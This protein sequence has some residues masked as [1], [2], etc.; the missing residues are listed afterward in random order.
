MTFFKH[1][2]NDLV[3]ARYYA[4]LR[5]IPVVIM[6][7]VSAMATQIMVFKD[8]VHWKW[9]IAMP[10]IMMGLG[11]FVFFYWLAHRN[12]TPTIKT[13]RFR[14][15]G[16]SFLLVLAG[17]ITVLGNLHL[18]G[19]T[20]GY[21]RYFIIFQTTLYGFCFAFILNKIGLAAYLYNLLIIPSVI[22][23]LF[24]AHIEYAL[25]LALMISIFEVGMLMTMNASANVFDSLVNAKYETQKLVDE[26]R[27]LANHDFL[28]NLAN[29]RLF[30][31]RVEEQLENA[32][33]YGQSF[34]VGIVDLDNFKPVNDAYGHH[35]GDLVLVEV[36]RRLSLLLPEILSF[37]RLGGDEFAFHL[38]GSQ[39]DLQLIG[40]EINRAI[41]EPIGIDGIIITLSASIGIATYPETRDSAQALY[42]HADFALY[43]AKRAGKAQLEVFSNIHQKQRLL[44]N[45]IDQA[46]RNAEIEAEFYP[47]FH[48]IVDSHAGITTGF[49][50]LT[51][52]RSPELKNVSPAQFIPVAESLG[53][54]SN[55]TI[56]MFR[57]SLEAMEKWPGQLS[58]SLN[59][60]A[61]DITN[62][63]VIMQ[64]IKELSQSAVNPG[65][66]IFEITETALVKDYSTA[67]ENIELLRASGVKIALDDFGTG[68]SS[69]S[70]V[71]HL[72]FDKLKIDRSFISG[73][74]TNLTSQTIVRS[75][76]ALCQGMQIECVAEGAETE[77][78]VRFLHGLGCSMVQ[79]FFYSQPLLENQVK[80][81][82]NEKDMFK[83]ADSEVGV[84]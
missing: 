62:Q 64:L 69:L 11:V 10:L 18:F 57:K 47:V 21:S 24:Y 26:N 81:F 39:Q 50:C 37:Y 43:Q 30:F 63:S 51:R 59:L 34:A 68:Y 71:Q 29:R 1:T 28:T 20:E 40:H 67:K 19:L 22:F 60:S 5:D 41:S 54:I 17:L 76:L 49:E 38:Y 42:E 83:V 79:G 35:I 45:Q 53:I 31:L 84:H 82:L 77:S 44:Q 6:A 61:Y 66:C 56:H 12:D 13:I 52:W 4:L 80:T 58:M 75:I 23:Y 36:A 65:R 48:P 55:L 73:I 2:R 8:N 25:P 3:L 72:P 33:L 15:N 70:H 9:S 16:F 74:E 78:Q 7:A 46:L 32:K 27:R 14:L